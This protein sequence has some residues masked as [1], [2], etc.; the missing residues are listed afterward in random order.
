MNCELSIV[1]P[2]YNGERFLRP[3]LDAVLAQTYRDWELLLIDDGSTDASGAICDEY[4]AADHRVTVIH[5][6]NVGHA[7]TRNRGIA[8]AKGEYVSFVDCDD[9]F[10]PDMYATMVG[11]LNDTKADIVVCGYYEEYADHTKAV[12]NDGRRQLC[13]ADDALKLV[14]QGT[15]GSYLW[16]MLFRRSV[17]REP[18]PSLKAYED[19]ATIFKWFAHARHVVLL[20]RAFYHYR[21]VEGSALHAY[22][23]VKNNHFFLAI[24]ERYH[25]VDDHS[26]LPGWEHENRRLY[27]RGCIKL[28]K[29][30][31]RQQHYDDRSRDLIC[32]VRREI[33]TFLPLTRRDVGSLK[34]YL[35]LRLL[36]LSVPLYV[37]L[38]R[39]S[40]FLAWG[41]HRKAKVY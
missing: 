8:M 31:A 30:V 24:K 18:M 20:H 4:A 40:S 6:E 36:L 23:P 38:L 32:D 19:H 28:T 29:D 39:L 41:K 26:L 9:W 14:L 21:Q 5:Q 1:L 35:R 16:S 34:Y 22:D 25:Y 15:V 3:C 10:E 17:V 33:A 12:A 11:T 37:R 2:V 27:L 13:T 7:A